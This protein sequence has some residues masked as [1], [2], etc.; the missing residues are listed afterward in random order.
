MEFVQ[1][2]DRV[3]SRLFKLPIDAQFCP[4]V[5]LDSKH[6]YSLNVCGPS[7]MFSS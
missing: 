6:D 2:V 3:E 5:V 7:W 1:Q 4:L